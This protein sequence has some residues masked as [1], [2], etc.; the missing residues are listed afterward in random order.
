ML[1]KSY[2]ATNVMNNHEIGNT[3]GTSTQ[4]N[5]SSDSIC[6]DASMPSGTISSTLSN[7]QIKSGTRDNQRRVGHTHAEQKRRYNIKNGF[8]QLRDLLPRLQNS[9][10]KVKKNL[11]YLFPHSEV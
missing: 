1:S 8:D 10:S 3:S 7:V 9:S 5:L 6:R 11:Y 4:L 2:V